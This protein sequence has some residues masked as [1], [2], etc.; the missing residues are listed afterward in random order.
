MKWNKKYVSVLA[1]VVIGAVIVC[2]IGY[3][4]TRTDSKTSETTQEQQVT[5]AEGQNSFSEEGTTQIKTESQLPEF[6]VGVVT[7]TVEE[8]YVEAGESVEEGTALFK[9]T[10]ESM[11]EAI[12]YYEEAIDDAKDALET[13]QLDFANGTLEAENELQDSQLTAD[14]AQST[15]DAALAELTLKVDEKKEAYDAAVEEIEAYQSA[16]DNGT[17][18]TQ[19][20]I[21]EKQAT[22]DA[23]GVSV[24]DAQ[25]ALSSAQ[26]TY[27]AAQTAMT[28][29]MENLKAQIAAN[30]SYETLLGLA[31]QVSADYTNVQAATRDLSQKQI[32]AD[33]AQSALEKAKLAQ[34]S[35]VKEYDMLVTKA[36]EKIEELFSSLEGLQEAYEQAERDATT[37][38]TTIQ[39][40]YEEAVLAG[41][42]AGT[43]YEATLAELADAVESAQMTLDELLEEQEAL[44]AV[45]D[46]VICANRAGTLASMP[47]EAEDVLISGVALAT[48]Y[49]TDTIYISVEVAQ[50]QIALLTV[51]DVVDVSV[52]GSRGMVNGEIASIA[53]EKTSGG[54]ISNVTYAVVIAIDNEEGRL[55][56]GSSATVMFDYEEDIT[57]GAE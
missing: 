7:M 29:D 10:E 32:A 15:Y 51:G 22:V 2:G 21:N 43:E 19:V 9:L 17:Y 23:A 38:Q 12:A 24:T 8:V 14:T 55:N 46:G 16:L 26:S 27:D 47:Y 57:E 37:A 39:K 41:K 45:E 44:L 53:T 18:Y 30:A 13:A 50:E 31:E 48:Y 5:Q 33:T 4:I 34:E 11:A 36:N 56:S 28:T 54:S 42:Y 25:T 3:R 35:A 6:A 20:G 52:T 40:E 1:V 49:D